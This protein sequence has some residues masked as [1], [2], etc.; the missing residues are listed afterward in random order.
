V[1]KVALVADDLTGALDAAAPFAARGLD[2]R[3]ATSVDA[4]ADLTGEP[5]VI[6]VS[7]NSRHMAA[8]RAQ[9]AVRAACAALA[10]RE[11]RIWFKKIDSTLRGN[12]AAESLAMLRATGLDEMLIT[13]ATPSQG[14]TVRGGEVLVN[15]TPLGETEFVH[16]AVSPASER[17]I[18]AQIGALDRSLT[19][20]VVN[21][22]PAPASNAAWVA[23]A[24]SD[25]ALE[26][27]ADWALDRADRC[28]MVGA[29]GLGRA[30][31]QRAFGAKRPLPAI[32]ALS[33]PILYVIGSRASKSVSQCA[34]LES[35]GGDVVHLDARC[36]L[37]DIGAARDAIAGH[38]TA[39]VRVPT[40]AEGMTPAAIARA[41]GRSVAALLGAAP[42]GAVLATGGD[43]VLA[44]LGALRADAV[45]L[46]GEV[47]P[48]IPLI[49]AD[50][51]GRPVWMVTKAGG[52]G[53]DDLFVRLPQIL[54]A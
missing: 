54:S 1:T 8:D 7:T 22:R 17:P 36:G 6:A 43:T 31:A 47:Q 40:D 42:I 49:R 38:A 33:G 14:R 53:D 32:G 3:V 5:Q 52:F 10:R 34:R 4:L 21:E 27:I 30:L 45:T 37:L 25:T 48:G 2:T 18:G 11:P 9:A 44:I 13:P 28:L 23:D 29:A 41:L 35:E 15:G 19:V 12:V 39:L 24:D 16:D 20:V 26:R 46:V 50:L 51:D